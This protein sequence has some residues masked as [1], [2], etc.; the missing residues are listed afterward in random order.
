[1]LVETAGGAGDRHRGGRAA[2]SARFASGFQLAYKPRS[3]AADRHFQDLLA[4]LNER[5]ARPA[6]RTLRTLDRGSHG[7]IEFVVAHGCRSEEEIRRFYERQGGFLALLYALEATDF[8]CENLIAAGEHPVMVDLEALFHPRAG[9]IDVKQAE[10]LATRTINYSVLRVGLLPE[11]MT[12]AEDPRGVDV[13]GLGSAAGQLSPY[14]V[15]TWEL[16]ATDEMRLT[17]RRVEMAGSANQPTLDDAGIDP[18]D[19]AAEIVAGFTRTYRLL[20]ERRDALLAAD[21][22]LARFAHDE[23]RVI[24]RATQTYATLLQASYHPDVQRDALDRERLLDY[25]WA[26]IEYAPFLAPV[27]PFEREDLLRGDIPVFTT[28][29]IARDLWTSAGE[30]IAGF[31]DESGLE[32]AAR[33][34]RQLD[35]A[36]LAQQLWFVRASL[37]TL[38]MEGEHAQGTGYRLEKPRSRAGRRRLLSAARAV[39]DRLEA[40][41]LRGDHDVSWL[42]LSLIDERHWNL[43]PLGTALY[44]GLPGVGLFLGHLGALT[45]E[46]RYSDLA[47]AAL[48]S[49][50]AQADHGQ[51]AIRTIGAFEGWGGLIYTLAHLGALWADASLWDRAEEL[52]A[53]LAPLIEPDEILDITAGAAGCLASLLAFYRCRPAEPALAAAIQC[54]E[55]LIALARPVEGGLGWSPSLPGARPLAGFSHGAAGIAWALLELAAL[56]GEERFRQTALAGIAF[57]RSV[58]QPEVGNWPDLRD[59][60]TLGIPGEGDDPF[61]S[62]AW[63]HGAPGI[64]LARLASLPQID[65]VEARREIETAVRTT[66]SSGFG[67]NHSLCHGDLGNLEFLLE[68]RRAGVGC[69]VDRIAAGIVKSIERDGWLCATPLGVESPGL[70]TGLAGI[71]Y[72]LLRLADPA[73]VPSVLMLAP[74][75]GMGG[76]AAARKSGRAAR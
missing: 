61:F 59:P 29:P 11:R 70:M 9:G 65:D 38:A 53:L 72:G 68:A 66:L 46:E 73:R 19:Y 62:T 35:E 45:R 6:F 37:A 49:A 47:R 24:L 54:G 43:V 8:H 18:L 7:W 52:V 51:A 30:R 69:P 34:L 27:I 4:W 5:G 56:T 33:R 26:G 67:L 58:F 40:L 74:P 28:R 55:R 31:F 17:R 63:C 23:V 12:T 71:G 39:G 57:E 60:A 10:Q 50:I 44:D 32:L 36:D 21:G 41:A 14:A 75:A 2:L 25:L 20:L 64:G 13:S 3:T 48:N 1:V 22:P 16:P 76:R 42:G 15:P